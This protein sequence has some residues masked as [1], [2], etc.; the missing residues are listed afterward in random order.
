[1]EDGRV[2]GH[3]HVADRGVEVGLGP[4]RALGEG[5][6]V[7]L[8]ARIGVVVALFDPHE[9]QLAV[10]PREVRCIEAAFGIEPVR[11]ES[12]GAAEAGVVAENRLA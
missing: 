1:M 6:D 10:L 5:L 8:L 4:S 9:G 12:D 3:Q 2:G 7:P 11:L